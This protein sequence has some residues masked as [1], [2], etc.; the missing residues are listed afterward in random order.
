MEEQERSSHK[1]N[2]LVDQVFERVDIFVSS[3]LER[4]AKKMNTH[5]IQNSFIDVLVGNIH[6][7]Q[8]YLLSVDVDETMKW[9]DELVGQQSQKTF[10][11]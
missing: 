9:F 1:K 10:V 8:W 4:L 5:I 6:F 11:S 2:L 3:K 7:Q